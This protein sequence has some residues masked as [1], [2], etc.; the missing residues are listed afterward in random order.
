MHLRYDVYI[1]KTLLNVLGTWMSIE[2]EILQ[3]AHKKENFS[4]YEYINVLV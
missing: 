3:K 2:A 1:N 4:A